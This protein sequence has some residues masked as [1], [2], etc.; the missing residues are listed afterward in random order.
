MDW[1]AE[2]AIA[3]AGTGFSGV[4]VGLQLMRALPAG[5]PCACWGASRPGR[6]VAYGNLRQPPAE[7]AGRPAGL[8]PAGRG[9]LCPLAGGRRP[10]CAAGRFRAPLLDGRLPAG[11]VGPGPGRGPRPR[12]A[13]AD[14]AAGCAACAACTTAGTWRRTMAARARPRRCCWPPAICR[15]RPRPGPR[16]RLAGPGLLAR[17]WQRPADW[18]PAPD[19]DVLLVG[20]GSPRWT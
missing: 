18:A 12:G 9:R 15:R 1:G 8:G 11:A 10:R 16:G 7:R 13:G 5:P 6:G 17:P 19:A 4:A 2:D 20:S 14:R 3:I